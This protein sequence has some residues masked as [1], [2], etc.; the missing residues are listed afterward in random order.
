M[1]NISTFHFSV[2]DSHLENTNSVFVHEDSFLKQNFAFPY[3]KIRSEGSRSLILPLMIIRNALKQEFENLAVNAIAINRR[4]RETLQVKLGEKVKVKT[5]TSKF[6]LDSI[7]KISFEIAPI[8][9]RPAKAMVL[10][11]LEIKDSFFRYIAAEPIN[12]EHPL[13]LPYT[14]F[15]LKLT[16]I[17]LETSEGSPAKTGILVSDK[18]VEIILKVNSQY[19]NIFTLTNK[20]LHRDNIPNISLNFKEWGVGGLGVEL[21]SLVER[22]L[23]SRLMPAEAVNRYGIKHTKGILLYGPP[24]T[25]KTLIARVIANMIG[26]K[27]KIVNGPELM[28]QYVGQSETNLRNIFKDAEKE[29]K[30]KGKD[31]D[32]HVIIFDEIDALFKK[33]GNLDS[34]MGQV[35]DSLV[36]QILTKLDGVEE[37]ENILIIGLTNRMDLLD[38]ALLR[39]G[40]IGVHIKIDLPDEAGRR[41]ILEIH[42]QKLR[43]ND[44]LDQK[45][46]LDDWAALTTRF[47]G[48]DLQ[49][50]V[51]EACYI[52]NIRNFEIREGKRPFFK[53]IDPKN[54][55]KVKQEDLEEAFEKVKPPYDTDSKVFAL[56][57][58]LSEREKQKARL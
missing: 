4:Q 42:T 2:C 37:I 47:S 43:E 32:L 44:L 45:V 31:S 17:Y 34:G 50:L 41:E 53:D 5:V 18:N 57:N 19:E 30:H 58:N 35:N 56:K 14:D 28:G 6:F 10:D 40:R 25:G 29:W 12:L 1:E 8:D 27:I 46:D 48:A 36:N 33:R 13:V 9:S 52:A 23:I 39:K 20:I 22:A 55:A 15:P 49:A 16:P 54:L 24:G 51:L 11:G 26:K 3:V 21:K 38:G 7:N